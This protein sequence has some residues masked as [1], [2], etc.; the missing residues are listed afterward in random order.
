MLHN[1]ATATMALYGL[2]IQPPGKP[3]HSKRHASS[4]PARVRRL[5]RDPTLTEPKDTIENPAIASYWLLFCCVRI[6]WFSKSRKQEQP[7]TRNPTEYSPASTLSRAS[8]IPGY[9]DNARPGEQMVMRRF[10][11][12]DYEVPLKSLTTKHKVRQDIRLDSVQSNETVY[13]PA[14][15]GQ[16]SSEKD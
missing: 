8:T 5:T 12:S 13:Y 3:H 9:Y 15:E 4:T 6:P 2:K 1:F 10:W 14:E 7:S 16:D 11:I